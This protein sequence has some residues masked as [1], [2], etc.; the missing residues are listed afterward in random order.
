MVGCGRLPYVRVT[1]HMRSRLCASEKARR[2]V[3][4]PQSGV[5]RLLHNSL[6]F[7]HH[8]FNALACVCV[9]RGLWGERPRPQPYNDSVDLGCTDGYTLN[10]SSPGRHMH[11]GATHDL[12]VPTLVLMT[13]PL[14]SLCVAVLGWCTCAR[15]SGAHGPS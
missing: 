12:A 9:K 5:V 13:W 11:A 2:C 15:V 6:V 3:Y 14:S 7:F 8:Q 1:P 10:A 4:T